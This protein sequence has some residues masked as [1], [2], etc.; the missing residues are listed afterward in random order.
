LLGGLCR[1]GPLPGLFNTRSQGLNNAFF[2]SAQL[3]GAIVVGQYLDQKTSS[4][5][6][7]A[8]ISFTLIM[9]TS[10]I[11]WGLAVWVQI[12]K[13]IDHADEH[14]VTDF[15]DGLPYVGIAAVYVLFGFCDAIIQCWCYWLIG[16]LTSDS[17]K[18][19]RYAGIYKFFQSGG[20][21]VAW[22]LN[23]S[24]LQALVQLFINISFFL[25]SIPGPAAVC[26]RHLSI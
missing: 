9:L 8:I 24:N 17:L 7:K 3:L 11:N 22:K 18:L 10:G 5:I 1:L 25:V 13:D 12:A 19:S 21:A 26:L 23:G 2:W 15:K 16:H 14:S 20:A 4:V 6:R